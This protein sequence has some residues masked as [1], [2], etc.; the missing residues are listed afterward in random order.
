MARSPSIRAA[1][2][3]IVFLPFG[4]SPIPSD[5]M[6][7]MHLQLTNNQIAQDLSTEGEVLAALRE[8]AAG[9]RVL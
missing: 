2:E 3:I 8:A 1:F 5:L 7:S 6:Q 4:Q 9:K